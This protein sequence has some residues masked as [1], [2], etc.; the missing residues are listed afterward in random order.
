[1]KHWQFVIS[2]LLISIL[3]KGISILWYDI[4]HK[5]ISLFNKSYETH[6]SFWSLW[7]FFIRKLA[8]TEII[9][10]AVAFI[11]TALLEGDF[12]KKIQKSFAIIV[13]ILSSLFIAVSFGLST[14]AIDITWI[15]ALKLGPISG[16]IRASNMFEA[17]PAFLSFL[18]VL[19]MCLFRY[20]NHILKSK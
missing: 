3:A 10:V 8:V 12:V 6:E 13:T 9:S 16:R 5:E 18:I 4:S 19:F 11:T 14:Y 1:M 2:L 7:N 20:R 15:Y 17:I